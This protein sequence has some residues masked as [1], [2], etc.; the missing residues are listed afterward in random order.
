MSYSLF[1]DKQAQP[2]PHEINEALG[3]AREQW[4]SL[5][6]F[7]RSHYRSQ[8][9][10][11]FLYGRD[12]GWGLRFRNK[13]NL[14]TAVFPNKNY[15]TSLVILNVKQLS[16]VESLK[17]HS[18]ARKAIESANLYAE[19]KWLFVRVGTSG[20]VVDVEKLIGLKA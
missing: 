4:T 3:E 15:F 2:S 16:S 17:L 11:K 1:T 5:I 8:E 13:G 19:G 6:E 10:F 18:S 9:D 7:L 12:Y 20:D 14:L